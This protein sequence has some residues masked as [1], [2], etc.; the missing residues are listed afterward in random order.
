[1]DRQD[2]LHLYSDEFKAEVFND[3]AEQP[4]LD[5]LHSAHASSSDLDRTLA[6]E[7]R[8]FTTD[9]NLCYTDK[10]SMAAGVEVRV[11]LLAKNL[12]EFA[13][14]I[15]EFI[16]IHVAILWIRVR[17]ALQIHQSTSAVS[18]RQFTSSPL[19]LGHYHG[20]AKALPWHCCGIA[21]VAP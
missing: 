2:L 15:L 3:L 14:T 5:F 8:F 11:P 10:M 18:V 17:L 12:V 4:M 9:H 19:L 21:M 20:T 7:Q 6:L 13:S 1:M 16:L